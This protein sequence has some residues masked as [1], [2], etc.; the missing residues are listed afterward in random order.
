M[1]LFLIRNLDNKDD[2]YKAWANRKDGVCSGG[3]LTKAPEIVAIFAGG[4]TRLRN[5]VNA[6]ISGARTHNGKLSEDNDMQIDQSK[7]AVIE[8]DFVDIA[9]PT[10]RFH[11]LD[12]ALALR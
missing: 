12:E 4:Y 6:V 11:T 10:I 5:F 1:K 2:I 7:L 9:K 8:I 3:Y